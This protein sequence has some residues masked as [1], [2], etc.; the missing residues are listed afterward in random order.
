MEIAVGKRYK[1]SKSGYYRIVEIENTRNITVQFERTKAFKRTT[2][3]NLRSGNLFD[4]E[5][6]LSRIGAEHKTKYGKITIIDRKS[7]DSIKIKFIG[8]GFEK[9][10]SWRS[11]KDQSI[12]DDSISDIIKKGD[13]FTTN[14]HGEVKVIKYE[15]SQKIKVKFLDTGYKT[16]TTQKA[17]RT[18]ELKDY[19]AKTIRGVA[20]FGDGKYSVKTHKKL[21]VI[22]TDLLARIY[23]AKTKKKMPAYDDA[24]IAED[25]L[26][27]QNF[28][29]DIVKMKNWDKPGF[30]LDKDWRVLG[31]KHYS[32]DTCSFMPR[33]MN[34]ALPDNAKG[35]SFHPKNPG[36]YVSTIP[37]NY[38][39]DHGLPWAYDD[40]KEAIKSFAIYRRDK[41]RLLA[42]KFKK[43][44]HPDVYHNMKNITVKQSRFRT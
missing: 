33:R 31:N 1:S 38:R 36:K 37:K 22:Y 20:C 5:G 11:I 21:Y 27:F 30:E 42:E 17:L 13:V 4:R 10:T 16:W 3:S 15:H 40:V 44:L 9:W 18:G 14:F 24:T 6:M 41:I 23:D 2:A 7:T 39:H 32:K 43:D 28:C 25:W 8:T 26:N 35:Y 29:S 34:S 12:V 19:L